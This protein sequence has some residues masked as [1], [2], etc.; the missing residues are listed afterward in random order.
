MSELNKA[1]EGRRAFYIDI[2]PAD[3][4]SAGASFTKQLA[5]QLKDAALKSG[6]ENLYVLAPYDGSAGA[7]APSPGA[8][9]GRRLTIFTS[10]LKEE[11]A[12]TGE[13]KPETVRSRYRVGTRFAPNPV[14]QAAREALAKAQA[15]ETDVQQDYEDALARLR[16]ATT[17]EER[18]AAEGD[19]DFE[20]RRWYDAQDNVTVAQQALAG[21][22]EN[23]EQ[24]VFQPYDY[25]VYSV[26]MN[27]QV[28]V[29]LEVADPESGVVRQLQVIGGAAAA[30]DRYTEAVSATDAE[31][32]KPDPKEL[33]TASELLA[34]AQR[35]RAARPSH[36]S[37]G[38]S[39]N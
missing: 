4:T 3:T 35:T 6:I 20:R 17:D 28:E 34:T 36:G 7:G 15:Q 21:T 32:A 10:L 27:A 22:P 31:G 39:R 30:T 25:L 33:P 13:N 37:R 29:S 12:S 26:T 19:V 23:V 14:Y 2:R 16:Q 9:G 18:A 5:Q 11:V 1:Y 8:G 38:R 24:E